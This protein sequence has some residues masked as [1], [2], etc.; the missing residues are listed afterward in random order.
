V[1]YPVDRVIQPL[2]KPGQ[3]SGLVALEAVGGVIVLSLFEGH[4]KTAN[5][6]AQNR[7]QY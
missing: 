6:P 4:Y 5:T 2:N 1:I 3:V 7:E